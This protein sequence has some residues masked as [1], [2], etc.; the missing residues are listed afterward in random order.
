MSKNNISMTEND[1]LSS[2]PARGFLSWIERKLDG[3]EAF[4]HQ[5]RIKK[6]R[7]DWNCDSIYN[8][9][10]NYVWTFHFRDPKN[11]TPISG[12]SF[13]E[14]E[15]VLDGLSATLRQS[16]LASDAVLCARTCC[17]IL[18]WGGVLIRNDACVAAIGDGICEYLQKV[19]T[20]LQKDLCSGEYYFDGMKMNSGFT[21]IYSLCADDFIIYDG[22]LGAALGLLSRLYCE[23]NGLSAIP[24]ELLFS[25]GR[26]KGGDPRRRDPSRGI[27]VY[28]EL[29]ANGKRHL[30]NNIRANWLIKEITRTTAS[31][32]GKL[33]PHS[34][35]RALESAL[36]MIGYQVN[37]ENE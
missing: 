34:R 5:F 29:G 12:S 15:Q 32:F 22:R 11:G 21:K 4:V 8:A 24:E 36:F 2:A 6:T 27:Y 10:E 13:A 26:G 19:R 33:E 18:S 7:T 1:F 20:R 3:P 37:N 30:E 9:Y 16:I 14:C 23:E 17:A 25:W 35:M 31:R 28:P